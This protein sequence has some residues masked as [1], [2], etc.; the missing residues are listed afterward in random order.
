MTIFTLA[1]SFALVQ[2]MTAGAAPKGHPMRE[3]FHFRSEADIPEDLSE[4]LFHAIV[5]YEEEE[6]RGYRITW[7]GRDWIVTDCITI[8]PKIDMTVELA[9]T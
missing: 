6:Q 1:D 5:L 8:Y 9:L 2:P 7:Q 4:A 3:T